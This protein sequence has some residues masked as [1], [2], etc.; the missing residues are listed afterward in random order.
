MKISTHGRYGLRMLIE[1]SLFDGKEYV[2]L[3]E[4]ARR[5]NVSSN[6]LESI[7]KPL[8]LA[9]ILDS[10]SGS[11]GGYRLSQPPEQ[12]SAYRV[13]ALLEG[14]F[15]ENGFSADSSNSTYRSFLND[16]VW[17]RLDDSVFEYL[18]S[19]TVFDLAHRTTDRLQEHE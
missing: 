1:L 6:Y 12:L 18:T 16:I 14:S 2:P 3:S 13:L 19:V 5:M 4:L 9:G 11:M 17:E 10:A 8:K 15:A 7:A